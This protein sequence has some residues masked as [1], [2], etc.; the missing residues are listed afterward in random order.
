M[1]DE[2]VEISS[3]YIETR[4]DFSKCDFVLQGHFPGA[5]V[6]PGA[7][8]QELC[9]QSAGLLMTKFHSPVEDY[10]SEKTKGYAVG[11]LNKINYAKFLKI[12]LPFELVSTKIKLE[13]KKENL[14]KFSAR[15]FQRD[16]LVSK[17][18]FHL[19]TISDEHLF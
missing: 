12:V 5:P 3:E 6:V 13:C 8:L 16:Q 15:V 1:V 9:T 7:M 19:V 10:D 14:F 18:S 11:V 2:V 4:K 17:L